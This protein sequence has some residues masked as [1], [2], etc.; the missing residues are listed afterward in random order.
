MR[1]KLVKTWH[2]TADEARETYAALNDCNVLSVD[3]NPRTKRDARK[4]AADFRAAQ[5]ELRLHER[6]LDMLCAG[7]VDRGF[8]RDL[9][10]RVLR[11]DKRI[12]PAIRCGTIEAAQLKEL[13]RIGYAVTPFDFSKSF[14]EYAHIA[15]ARS[16]LLNN[17][18]ENMDRS[19]ARTIKENRT[20]R[21]IRQENPDIGGDIVYGVFVGALHAP[22]LYLPSGYVNLCE[23][24]PRAEETWLLSDQIKKRQNRDDAEELLA[25]QYVCS[26]VYLVGSSDALNESNV[27][28]VEEQIR[29]ADISRADVCNF[30]DRFRGTDCGQS[31]KAVYDFLRSKGIIPENIG[32]NC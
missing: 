2:Q 12:F 21:L 23:V 19:I 14:D 17:L 4:H 7:V 32:V 1:V 9:Q 16:R 13:Y 24:L 27:L 6:A 11:S 10:G 8:V 30:S 26:L 18:I 15:W 3:E 20:E 31:S 28:F 25:R 22:E 5:S 29:G